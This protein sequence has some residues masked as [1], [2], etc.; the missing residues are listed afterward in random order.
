MDYEFLEPEKLDENTGL[1][2][3]I[4]SHLD[5]LEKGLRLVANEVATDNGRIDS[6]AIDEQKNIVIIEYKTIE[7]D[8]ALIQALNYADWIEKH[9]GDVIRLAAERFKENIDEIKNIRIFLVAPSFSTK[10]KN[11]IDMIDEP[12][13]LLF[14]FTTYKNNKISI[15]L[16][17]A[18]QS[19]RIPQIYNIEDHFQR[20]NAAMRPLFNKLKEEIEKFG[21]EK[22]TLEATKFYIGVKRKH[23][24]AVIYIYNSRIDILFGLKNRPDSPRIQD[25]EWGSWTNCAV[26]IRQPEDIN[27]ELLRWLKESYEI[28]GNK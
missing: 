27:E 15:N 24:F 8:N 16:V 21:P 11:A 7:D 12:E 13:I 18:A 20:G 26:E 9:P 4:N 2:P 25:S 22:P 10:L 17:P 3:L 1:R 5:K 19:S 23:L 28:H 6:L 14:E